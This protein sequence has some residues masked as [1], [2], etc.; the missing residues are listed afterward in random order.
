[1]GVGRLFVFIIRMVMSL[2]KQDLCGGGIRCYFDLFRRDNFA[3]GWE[4][5]VKVD[6]GMYNTGGGRRCEVGK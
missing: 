5:G 2:V 3:T 4:I 6:V 1:M